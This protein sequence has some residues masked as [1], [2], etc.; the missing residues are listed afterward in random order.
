MLFAYVMSLL[1]FTCCYVR[2]CNMNKVFVAHLLNPPP[3]EEDLPSLRSNIALMLFAYVMSLL[4]FTCCYV[5]ACNMNKVFVAHLLNPPPREEDL[6]SLRSNI[7]L[8]LFAYV[9]SL[10]TDTYNSS[11]WHP[12]TS[13]I[14][15]ENVSTNESRTVTSMLHS[16][17][18][19]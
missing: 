3:R 16:I 13:F 8:M 12:S 9:M 18:N 17:S 2:A 6:P 15:S 14:F 7:A 1:T 4:T 5:R 11:R 19:F 10:L